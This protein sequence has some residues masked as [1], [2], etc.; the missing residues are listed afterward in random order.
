MFSHISSSF[1]FLT[2][3]HLHKSKGNPSP[4]ALVKKLVSSEKFTIFAD[5]WTQLKFIKHESWI[6]IKKKNMKSWQKITQ[7][8]KYS[9]N[10]AISI[11][12][13]FCNY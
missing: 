2:N 1:C 9:A 11:D 8:I 4:G 13:Y 10:N 12:C 6:E 3:A 5:I 7:N